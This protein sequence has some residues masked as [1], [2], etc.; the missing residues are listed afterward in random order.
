MTLRPTMS[1]A[2]N[3]YRERIPSPAFETMLISSRGDTDGNDNT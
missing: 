1:E 3:N 2:E